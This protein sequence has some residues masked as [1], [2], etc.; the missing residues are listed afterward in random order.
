MSDYPELMVKACV[1]LEAARYKTPTTMWF[2]N[3]FGPVL[4]AHLPRGQWPK[5]WAGAL[6]EDMRRA[7]LV[8]LDREAMRGY[9][10]STKRY[11]L[12]QAGRDL[13]WAP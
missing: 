12:T 8:E 7:G 11:R 1:F 5:N 6:L 2:G 3:H 10:G 9:V 13:G 4:Y